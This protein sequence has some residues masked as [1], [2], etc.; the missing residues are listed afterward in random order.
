MRTSFFLK[1]YHCN[2]VLMIDKFPFLDLK[3]ATG[4][5][6]SSYQMCCFCKKKKKGEEKKTAWI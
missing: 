6:C 1:K 3:T 4:Q 2:F 5:K